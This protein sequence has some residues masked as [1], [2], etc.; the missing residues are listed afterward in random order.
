MPVV[1]GYNPEFF[2]N[3]GGGR[4]QAIVE[5][6]GWRPWVRFVRCSCLWQPEEVELLDGHLQVSDD[7]Q[8]VHI[9]CRRAAGGFT[10]VAERVEVG[11]ISKDLHDSM[12]DRSSW[13]LRGLVILSGN[14]DVTANR[15]RRGIENVWGGIPGLIVVAEHLYGDTQE[16]SVPLPLIV[17]VISFITGVKHR[18]CLHDV[19]GMHRRLLYLSEGIFVWRGGC[20]LTTRRGV[21]GVVIEE[22]HERERMSL[23]SR[24]LLLLTAWTFPPW[25]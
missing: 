16:L 25:A 13:G 1:S 11:V 10:W 15:S 2:H 5:V 9:S 20:G 4:A 7:E 22:R 6:R 14:E 23:L 12:K 21:V 18:D 17:A 19:C 24:S 8:L 3:F